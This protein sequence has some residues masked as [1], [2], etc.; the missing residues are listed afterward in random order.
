MGGE[1]KANDFV[2]QFRFLKGMGNG[3][4]WGQAMPFCLTGGGGNHCAGE[5]G[6]SGRFRAD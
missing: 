3:G 5:S 2:L 6:C 1:E 4:G